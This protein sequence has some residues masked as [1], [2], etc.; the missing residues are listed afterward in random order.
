MNTSLFSRLLA[1]A[2]FA[3]PIENAHAQAGGNSGAVGSSSGGALT[4]G[5]AAGSFVQLIAF[6]EVQKDLALS[7][8]QKVG[9]AAVLQR[10]S[11]HDKQ[12]LEGLKNPPARPN[13]QWH[14]QRQELTR[15]VM[16]QAERSINLVLSPAQIQ[17]LEQISL[18][19]L[20]AAALFQPGVAKA[21]N[22]SAAQQQ[23]LAQLRQQADQQVFALLKSLSTSPARRSAAVSVTS[24]QPGARAAAGGTTTAQSGAGFTSDK[25]FGEIRRESE[26]KMLE[27][28]L[29][30]PQQAKLNELKGKP[31]PLPPH[32]AIRSGGSSGGFSRSGGSGGPR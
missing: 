18:Q 5:G 16:A 13:A 14:M 22:L 21:L 4:S 20:G 15:Q 1:L 25:R 26:R 11:L 10:V 27:E 6:P 3:G 9:V 17:R 7:D 24:E 23:Q 12:M 31:C 30:P 32:F 28:V 29:T 8:Q 2:V 19:E